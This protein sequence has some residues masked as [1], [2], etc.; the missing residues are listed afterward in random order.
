MGCLSPISLVKGNSVLFQKRAK[1]ILKRNLG[2][3]FREKCVDLP[4]NILVG[5]KRKSLTG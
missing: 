3:M 2:M 5:Q 1:L 4:A